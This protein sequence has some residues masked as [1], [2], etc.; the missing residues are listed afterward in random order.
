MFIQKDTHIVAYLYI[1]LKI[2][3]S[4]KLLNR[5]FLRDFLQ[6]INFRLYEWFFALQ[7]PDNI[8]DEIWGR[9][10]QTNTANLDKINSTVV[11]NKFLYS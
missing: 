8:K 2:I 6:N 3:L 4:L 7:Q 1:Y 9:S 5:C 11:G 10:K